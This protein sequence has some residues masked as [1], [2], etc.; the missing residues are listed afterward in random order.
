MLAKSHEI[1]HHKIKYH[2]STGLSRTAWKA[3]IEGTQGQGAG[4]DSREKRTDER[5]RREGRGGKELSS[6]ENSVASRYWVR[7]RMANEMP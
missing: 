6:W 1:V 3:Q 2:F 5:Q 7:Q 4:N